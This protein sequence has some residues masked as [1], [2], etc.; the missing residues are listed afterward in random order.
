MSLGHLLLEEGVD[1]ELSTDMRELIRL[2]DSEIPGFTCEGYGYSVSL[3]KG[4]VGSRLSLMVKPW[5]LA[6]GVTLDPAVALV[7]IESLESGSVSLRIPPRA[8]WGDDEST[9]MDP[10]GKLFASF[11]FHLLN[12]L[13]RHN[14]LDLP[15]CLPIA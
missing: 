15:G 6:S 13:Q 2:L 1:M 11:V 9:A 8:E 5:D 10:E 7:E 14:L 4:T 3:M 12:S